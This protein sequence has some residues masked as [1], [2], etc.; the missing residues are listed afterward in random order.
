MIEVGQYGKRAM[1][2]IDAEARAMT[3]GRNKSA[4][5]FDA[6]NARINSIFAARTLPR[7]ADALHSYVLDDR[8]VLM[9]VAIC[10]HEMRRAN[11]AFLWLQ[12]VREG[13]IPDVF[14]L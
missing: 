9:L 6:V 2:D 13:A 12:H 3:M 1:K 8:Y 7:R 4:D 5:P 11:S 14:K 10:T